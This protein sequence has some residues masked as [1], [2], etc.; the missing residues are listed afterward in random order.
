MSSL[1]NDMAVFHNQDHIGFFDGRKSVS[2]YKA[3]ASFHKLGKGTLY[4]KFRSGVDGTGSFVENKDLRVGEDSAG[5]SNQLALSHGQ[6][7]ASLR[8]FRVV[9]LFKLHDEVVGIN[10]LGCGNDFLIGGIK[11]TVTDVVTDCAAE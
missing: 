11:L 2:Y 3:G 9:T 10:G 6:S 1:F 8:K 7:A 5:K 4:L